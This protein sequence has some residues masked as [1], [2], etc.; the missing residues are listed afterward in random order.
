MK[1]RDRDELIGGTFFTWFQ[2]VTP[3][4]AFFTLPET[5]A[6]SHSA[7]ETETRP[8]RA[9]EVLPPLEAESAAA[10]LRNLIPSVCTGSPERRGGTEEADNQLCSQRRSVP[11]RAHLPAFVL[12]GDVH[13]VDSGH[14]R[15]GLLSTEGQTTRPP[16]EGQREDSAQSRST[17]ASPCPLSFFQTGCNDTQMKQISC[18]NGK[19]WQI[20]GAFPARNSHAHIH[21]PQHGKCAPRRSSGFLALCSSQI[22]G[23]EQGCG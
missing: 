22:K 13:S 8:C 2:G 14:P 4:P 5:Q 23:G 20:H 6:I 7:V 17:Q 12:L 18:V 21:M 16:T 1:A 10:M 15:G 19:F 9:R 3:I 11:H